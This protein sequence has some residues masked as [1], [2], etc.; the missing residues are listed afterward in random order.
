MREGQWDIAY[1]FMSQDFWLGNGV[2]FTGE[3]LNS[4]GE[5]GLFGAEGM[6][7]PIM[8]D[9]GMLGVICTLSSFILGLFYI[10]RW[11]HYKMLWLWA[12]FLLLKTITTGVGVEVT[13]YEIILVVLFRYAEF[14]DENSEYTYLCEEMD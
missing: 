14:I 11:K 10:L 12:S 7:L 5:A 1:Q 4:G 13:Y 9:R 2:H 3:M 8:M 6:W